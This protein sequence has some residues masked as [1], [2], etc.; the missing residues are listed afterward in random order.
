MGLSTAQRKAVT[1]EM[2][3]RDQRATKKEK[4]RMLDEL[5]ALTGWSRRHA[6]RSLHQAVHS[7]QRVPGAPGPR[8]YGPDVLGPL[9]RIWATLDGP[10][11]KPLA[12][13]QDVGWP[14]RGPNRLPEL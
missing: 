5:C 10:T 3:K 1:K 7:P 4:A 12:Q 8:T 14:T 6:I 13:G 9:R 11:G 2:A